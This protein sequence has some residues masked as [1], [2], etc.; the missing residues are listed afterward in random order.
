MEHIYYVAV[1]GDDAWSGLLPEPNAAGT[2]G[3]FATL[4]HAVDAAREVGAGTARRIVVR[5]GAYYEV[6]VTLDER[7]SGLTIEAAAGETPVLYGGRVVSGWQPEGQVLSAA[8]PEVASGAW[9]FRLLV[10]NGEMRPR[11]RYPESGALTHESVFDVRWMTSTGGGWERPPTEEELTTLKYREGDLGAWLDVANAE[12]TVY[13][14]WDDSMVGVAANDVAVRT[15]T[16]SSPT[17]HPPGGFGSWLE[18]ARTYVVWNIREGLTKPGQWYLDRTAGRVVYWPLAGETAETIAAVAPTTERIVSI[19]GRDGAVVRDLTL[20][21]LSLVATNTPLISA[22][23]GAAQLDGAVAGAAPLE[24][25]RFEALTLNSVAGYGISVK[26]GIQNRSEVGVRRERPSPNKRISVAHCTMAR[27]GAGAVHLLAQDSTITDNTVEHVGLM[28]PAAI[29]LWFTGDRNEVSHNAIRHASYDAVAGH[30]GKGSRVEYNLF[31]DVMQV[32]QDGAAIYVFYVEDLVMRGN[33][34]RASRGAMVAAH[35]YYL[36]E[37]S[38]N[39]DIAENLAIGVGWPSHNHMAQGN[40]I[41]GNVFIVDGDARLSFT[42]SSGTTLEK[43]VVYATGSIALRATNAIAEF[44]RNI[45]YSGTGTVTGIAEPQTYVPGGPI[46]GKVAGT[47]EPEPQE[48]GLES[49][50]GTLLADPGFVDL[51]G[52]DLSFLPDSPARR[53]GI[54]P[55]DVRLAGPR[56]R[57]A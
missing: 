49:G 6:A 15:L 50:E 30:F 3:P 17:G 25:C 55:I 45:F 46:V 8:L 21:G 28:Y 31:E 42:R 23:F 29:G 5:G 7:D 38:A 27:L 14:A 47:G 35:A 20:R 36:D 16:F 4:E 41:W 2:D 37:F 19:A 12:V 48:Y 32:L 44:H 9:D 57:T 10:V 51:A 26:D 22:G 56:P 33:V 1:N 24:D 18:H 53:W 39:C 11:A 34:T 54:L 52:G 40:R 13:H 43:N